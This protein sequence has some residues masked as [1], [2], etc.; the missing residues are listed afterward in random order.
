MKKKGPYTPK[1][2]PEKN[3]HKKTRIK[4]WTLEGR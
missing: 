3:T 2:D 4:I 1:K